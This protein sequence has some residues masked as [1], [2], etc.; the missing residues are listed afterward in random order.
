MRVLHVAHYYKPHVGG[1][2]RHLGE[3]SNVLKTQGIQTTI[4]T[5]Q[6][7][8]SLPEYESYP[9]AE[10]FRI[11]VDESS[12]FLH[13]VSVWKGVW[14]AK[15][16][17]FRADVIHVH[18]VFWW[19]L[20]LLP[21]LLLYRKKI[22]MTFHGYA[23]N[24]LPTKYE[25]LW[26]KIA[27]FFTKGSICVGDFQKKWFHLSP[28][29]VVYGAVDSTL[30]QK[31]VP[32]TAIFLGRLEQDNGIFLYL[33]A[34]R[35]VQ[36]HDSRWKLAVYGEGSQE[37]AAK[38]FVAK[39]KLNVTFHGFVPLEQKQISHYSVAF[40]SRYLSIIEALSARVAVISQYTTRMTE[41]YL[42]MSPFS[43]WITI[44]NTPEA[45]V[46]ALLK[47]KKVTEAASKWVAAQTWDNLADVYKKLWS[48]QR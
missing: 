32:Q 29:K 43:D 38:A 10:V 41:D 35:Q 9:E 34:L 47:P 7:D 48:E 16:H 8:V 31:K 1:V 46:A 20:V 6:Y 24:E 3:I 23:G 17:F 26:R 12:K 19:V 11:H 14:Q 40:V 4:L 22:Y 21:W 15:N 44:A 25:I 42:R 13:K 27:A 2:E 30:P 33:E 37:K 45:V 36:A 18:D 5:K 28:T 39:H